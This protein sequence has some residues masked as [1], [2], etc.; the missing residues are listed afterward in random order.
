MPHD[1][2]LTFIGHAAWRIQ[3]DR[4][5]LLID[6]F[7]TDNPLAALD[8]NDLHPTHILVSHGH[9]DHLG[10][11]V[12]LA[13]TSGATVIA[14]FETVNW[15]RRQGVEHAHP[16]SIGGSYGFEFGR[17]KQTPA[18]HGC[19]LPDGSYGGQPA[20]LL[21]TIGSHTIYHA[22]D[23]ALFSDMKLIGA[24]HRIDV[25]LLPIGDN[26]TMGVDDAVTA[27]ELLAPK[28]VIPMHYNTFD[29]IRADPEEF[30]SKVEGTGH[31]AL[32]LNPGESYELVNAAP[33]T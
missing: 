24:R 5:E 22:G 32:I 28:L 21:V 23:T 10:D 17:V 4:F 20:G 15:L 26:F 16:M 27:V 8:V 31:K 11:T 14:S 2:T 9:S 29:V 33:S 6:P 30:R 12:A 7:I 18:F 19:A 25:A 3:S 13:R 1:T